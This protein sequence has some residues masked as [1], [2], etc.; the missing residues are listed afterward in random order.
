M[1][2]SFLFAFVLFLSVHNLF[3]NTQNTQTDKIPSYVQEEIS[4][5][6]AK[7]KKRAYICMGLGATAVAGSLGSLIYFSKL[8]NTKKKYDFA[9]KMEKWAEIDSNAKKPVKSFKEYYDEEL[10]KENTTVA[11]WFNKIIEI[12]N[13]GYTFESPNQVTI[14][15]T[16][17]QDASMISAPFYTIIDH[18]AKQNNTS[19]K[20][21]VIPG[22]SGVAL[23]SY[24]LYCLS[25]AK[26]LENNFFEQKPIE[27]VQE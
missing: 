18:L 15:R 5:E 6:V 1:K 19:K 21:A 26:K 20:L 11:H 23:F 8:S 27:A 2:K 13:D 9:Q 25:K 24:G 14:T 17:F 22:V 10:T 16:N 7:L 4:K 3:P 12:N